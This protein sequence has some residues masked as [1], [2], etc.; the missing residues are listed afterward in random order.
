MSATDTTDTAGMGYLDSRTRRAVTVY[1]PLVAFVAG[2]A[3]L[4]GVM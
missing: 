3:V 4:Q 1:A 2:G